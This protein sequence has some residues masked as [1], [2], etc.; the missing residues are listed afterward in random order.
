M[1]NFVTVIALMVSMAGIFVSLARE[2]LRCKLGLSGEACQPSAENFKKS[3]KNP[4]NDSDFTKPLSEVLNNKP[5]SVEQ[6]A[7]EKP[8]SQSIT[9]LNSRKQTDQKTIESDADT[10]ATKILKSDTENSDKLIIP[11]AESGTST[12]ENTTPD[13]ISPE[14]N[15]PDHESNPMAND[16]SAASANGS[17]HSEHSDDNA[18]QPIPVIP[19]PQTN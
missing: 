5:E 7:L 6:G 15:S 16:D 4:V 11:S 18:S 19:P 17:A 13:S 2:E 10:K 14:L 12:P 3:P 9:P 8:S 1:R